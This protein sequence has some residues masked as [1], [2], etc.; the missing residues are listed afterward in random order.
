MR[1]IIIS[2]IASQK[3]IDIADY[4]EIKFSLKDRNK[5][6]DKFEKTLMLIQKNPEIFPKSEINKGQSRCVMTK[7]TTLYFRYSSV[8]V[9]ILAV[10]DTRQSPTKIKKIK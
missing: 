8:Q 1:K 2:T 3:L 6:I 5:F 4:I 7:Q 10:F 9:R